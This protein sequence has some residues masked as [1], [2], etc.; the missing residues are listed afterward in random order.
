MY[1][2]PESKHLRNLKRDRIDPGESALNEGSLE[3][4]NPS[5]LSICARSFWSLL[6]LFL[7]ILG[8]YISIWNF[9]SVKIVE[10]NGRSTFNDG[11]GLPLLVDSPHR[12]GQTGWRVL[13]STRRE[14]GTGSAKEQ[15]AVEMRPAAGITER[16]EGQEAG[17]WYLCRE[18]GF[19]SA[20]E[21]QPA[22]VP[23]RH[24]IP[25]GP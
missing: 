14:K 9:I 10:M 12:V 22:H 18:D 4:D 6:F 23:H 13:V 17:R 15:M 1:N 21:P 24:L 8:R 16:M 2:S 11:M 20:R 3:V 7:V 25:P 19:F 5:L